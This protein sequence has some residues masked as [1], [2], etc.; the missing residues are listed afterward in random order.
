MT[1]LEWLLSLHVEDIEKRYYREKYCTL[2]IYDGSGECDKR[3][4]IEGKLKWLNE[5][6]V[7]KIKPCPFCGGKAIVDKNQ[8]SVS[9]ADCHMGTSWTDSIEDAIKTWNRRVGN[10]KVD[11]D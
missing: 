5:E 9:C 7:P 11:G 10:G 8:N 6:H 4:C 1:N 2:C 3:S